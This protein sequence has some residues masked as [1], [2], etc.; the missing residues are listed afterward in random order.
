[1]NPLRPLPCARLVLLT[2]GAALLATQGAACELVPLANPGRSATLDTRQPTLSWRGDAAA[3]YRVQVAAV[4]PESRVV[5]THDVEVTGTSFTLP[6]PVPSERAS[7]KVLVTR[8]CPP[9]DAQDL[10][11]QGP[12]FFIDVRAAC[13]LDPASLNPAASGWKW[14]GVPAAQSYSLRLFGWDAASGR[15][16]HL[17]Q[18]SLSQPLWEPTA[19]EM[20]EGRK[21]DL[22]ASVQP[23][24]NGQPGRPLAWRLGD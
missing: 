2:L 7:V 6:A 19:L 9:G 16:A 4:L 23:V 13:S 21:G 20:A 22:V 11:A 18:W 1:M 5:A 12:W 3:R 15:L 8:G 10:H 24:C 14:A 17:R